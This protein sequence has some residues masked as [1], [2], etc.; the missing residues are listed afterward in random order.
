MTTAEVEAALGVLLGAEP[1]VARRA[2]AALADAG[3]LASGLLLPAALL[4]AR[5]G[6]DLVGGIEALADGTPPPR[7]WSAYEQRAAADEV[8]DDLTRQLDRL[9]PGGE[10]VRLEEGAD[11]ADAVAALLAGAGGLSG[12]VS[13]AAADLLHRLAERAGLRLDLTA[14]DGEGTPPGATSTS[15]A[16]LGLPT[17]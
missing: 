5:S 17:A 11:A 10:V 8:A 13:G 16:H 3:V 12:R 7:T 6:R 14:D 15:A 2:A 4:A 1:A 9:D